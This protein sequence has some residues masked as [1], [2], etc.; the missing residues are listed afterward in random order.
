MVER[1]A[2]RGEKVDV[3][4]GEKTHAACLWFSLHVLTSRIVPF[5]WNHE[6]DATGKIVI[7]KAAHAQTH[8]HTIDSQNSC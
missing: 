1:T 8:T 4:G 6:M 7:T 3:I 5:R 2:E